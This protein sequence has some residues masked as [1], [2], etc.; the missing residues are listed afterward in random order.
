MR[1]LFAS[2]RL[3]IF[4]LAIMVTLMMVSAVSESAVMDELAHVPAG[5]SYVTQFDYRLNP[6]HPPLIKA[7]SGLF[8]RIFVNPHFP[9]DT[10]Y[11]HNDINGQWAQGTA[12]LYESGNN[13]DAMIFWSRIPIILLALLFGWLMYYWVKKRFGNF[14]ALLTLCFFA[15]SPTFLAHSHYVTTDLGAAFGFFIGITSFVTF[16]EDPSWKRAVYA[17]LAF[18]LAQL[19]KFSLVLLLPIDLLLFLIWAAVMPA[20]TMRERLKKACRILGKFVVAGFIALVLIWIVYA[21]FVWNYPQERQLADATYLLS[22]YGFHPAVNLDLSLIK[23]SFLRPLGQYI[24]GVL[25]VQQRSQGGNSAFFLGEMSSVGSRLYFPL[26]YLVKEP[27]PLHIFTL[28]SLMYAYIA[29]KRWRAR[30]RDQSLI[31]KLRESVSNHFALVAGGVFIF[32]YWLI[33]IKS[34]LNIG[35]RHLM[36]TFPFIYMIVARGVSGWIRT[37]E[38]SDPQTFFTFL[39][40]IYRM[41]VKTLPKYAFVGV[42]LFWLAIGTINATPDFLPYY[43]K[44]GGST[45]DGWRIAVDSN[46]DWGQDLN[47]LVDF[48]NEQGIDKIGLHY[49]GAGTPR[50]YLGDRVYQWWPHLGK[51]PGWYAV[52]AT[53]RQGAFGTPV[54]GFIKPAQD[55]FD[56]LKQYEPVARAGN[57]IFIYYFPEGTAGN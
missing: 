44:L 2:N 17:G 14:P 31:K 51:K 3:A 34:P 20:Y 40:T 29:A 49:F 36:P 46:Y 43:N 33:T 27:L 5:Y 9:T 47:R 10:R 45:R 12:F 54:P 39:R 50:F 56:W 48:V 21:V 13:P 41:T 30:D 16:L 11:W 53:F 15:F 32:F 1:T 38:D 57:S 18:G 35:V 19:L 37:P 26:L 55:Q 8:L 28:V 25:M 4:I 7:L 23:N 22:T 24:L 52:S 6:E 42:A